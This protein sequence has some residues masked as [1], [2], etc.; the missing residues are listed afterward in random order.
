MPKQKWTLGDIRPPERA[1]SEPPASARGAGTSRTERP[2]ARETA[3]SGGRK[4]IRSRVHRKKAVFFGGLAL[5]LALVGVGISLLMRGAELTVYPKFQDIS[6]NAT[7]IADRN[8]ETDALG[9]ELLTLEES[10]E[11]AV[12]ATGS[13]Q[14]EERAKGELTIYNAFSAESQR[15]I[16]NTRF[17]SPDGRIFRI[18]DSVVVPGYTTSATGEKT[19][20]SAKAQVFADAAGAEYNIAP[21]RFTIPGFK[22][23]PQ[24]DG[25]YAEPTAPMTGG[26][27][28]TR[29]IVDETTLRGARDAI[30]GELRERLME[31]LHSERP[32]G[33]AFYESAARVSF[34]SLPTESADDAQAVIRERALLEIPLFAEADLAAYLARNTIIG[35]DGAPVRVEDPAGLAFSYQSA[36][37][38]ALSAEERIAFTLAG[39][40]RL[41]WTYDKNKLRDDVAGAA[42]GDLPTILLSYEPAIARARAVMRPFWRQSFPKDPTKIKI[43]EVLDSPTQ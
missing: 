14:A 19:P 40:A 13:E 17:E 23:T 32:A 5:L 3:R 33:F 39:D 27:I 30:D 29:L 20:G 8:P 31:R 9:Y 22:G 21:S 7:F 43:I 1:A 6:V 15:L 4:K 41:I 2:L 37:T 28:G 42:K 26:F 25:M 11:R 10:G 38:A 36:P 18:S 34:E 24:F 35:Y 16:K 12:A